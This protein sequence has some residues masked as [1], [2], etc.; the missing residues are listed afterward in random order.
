MSTESIDDNVRRGGRAKKSGAR[1]EGDN[2][3]QDHCK[4]RE[5]NNNNDAVVV[6]A[7]GVRGECA[8]NN[9]GRLKSQSCRREGEGWAPLSLAGCRNNG[10]DAKRAVNV[11]EG[12]E[13]PTT[14]MT[15]TTTTTT[16]EATGAS[17]VPAGDLLTATSPPPGSIGDD[18]NNVNDEM[19]KG[20][21]R[22]W[23]RLRR[24][25]EA[26]RGENG[27]THTL[28]VSHGSRKNPP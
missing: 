25:R 28:R 10:V 6:A 27:G 16:E 18:V 9:A 7:D 3:P 21:G 15:T 5:P 26:K 8:A 22:I 24:G 23:V 2:R 4:G 20:E 11:Q 1:R 13:D 12:E 17:E 14:T 19:T